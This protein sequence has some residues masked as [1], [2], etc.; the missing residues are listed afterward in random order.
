MPLTCLCSQNQILSFNY[1]EQPL[2]LM[3]SVTALL[4]LIRAEGLG[5][6]FFF[7]LLCSDRK[8]VNKKKRGTAELR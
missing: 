2:S 1:P 8:E 4:T 5:F 3:S 6:S 7:F